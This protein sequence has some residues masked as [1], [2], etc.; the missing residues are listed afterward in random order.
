[1]EDQGKLIK[2]QNL[3]LEAYLNYERERNRKVRDNEFAKW[4]G[5]SANSFN[6]WI[7]GNRIPS[8]DNAIKLSRRLG[9]EVFSVLG[10][11][12][13]TI[14]NYPDLIFLVEHWEEFDNEVKRQIMELA[15]KNISVD[16]TQQS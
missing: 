1:M 2:F 6:A 10:F 11:P 4:L 14:A 5:V 13:V 16:A 15:S 7:N 8:Y 12:P 3:L 9:K